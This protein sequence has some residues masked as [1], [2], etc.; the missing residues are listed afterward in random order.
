MKNL[1]AVKVYIITLCKGCNYFISLI[2]AIFVKVREKVGF[3]GGGKLSFGLF[4][5]EFHLNDK[6]FFAD[7]KEKEELSGSI[8]GEQILTG[9]RSELF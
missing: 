1:I 6:W 3:G 8:R 2:Q 5:K 9:R 7:R 4:W